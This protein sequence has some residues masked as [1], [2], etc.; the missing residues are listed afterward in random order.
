MNHPVASGEDLRPAALS[1]PD[2][3]APHSLEESRLLS[4]LAT[5]STLAGAASVVWIAWR[6]LG[7]GPDRAAA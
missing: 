6:T 7:R 2:G 3:H 5:A 4:G 1:G